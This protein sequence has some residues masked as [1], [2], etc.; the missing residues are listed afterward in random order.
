MLSKML[1]CLVM[2][3]AL[4]ITYGVGVILLVKFALY[5]LCKKGG[6]Y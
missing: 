4:G 3:G 1:L 5:L 6:K 2:L